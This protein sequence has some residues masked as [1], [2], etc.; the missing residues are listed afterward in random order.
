MNPSLNIVSSSHL[1][2][3]RSAELSEFEFG[4]M[5]VS[6]AFNR[7]M[8]RCMAAAGEKD[9][10]AMDVALLHHVNHLGRKKKLADICFVL[11]IEDTH[12]VSYALKKLV[13][14]GHV[15]SEKIGK[16]VLFSTTPAGTAL[17][18]RYREVRERC[19]IGA[20]VESG[21]SNAEI[22]NTA[23]LLRVLSGLY[24]QAARA[25]ASL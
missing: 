6:N 14:A 10:T 21:A 17:C 23:Q 16:E 11:N 9:M 12:V 7:W 15:A 5:V 22:G 4:L 1:V 25:G 2:S 8:V 24:D 3:E 13:R 18:E 20:L 19:L